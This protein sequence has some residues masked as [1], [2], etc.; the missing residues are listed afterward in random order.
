[1]QK[2][3]DNAIAVG[4]SHLTIPAGHYQFTGRSKQLVIKDASNLVIRGDGPEATSFWF[5]PGYGVQVLSCVDMTLSGVS[6]DTITPSHSQSKFVS[7]THSSTNPRNAKLVVD[8]EDGFPLLDDPYLFNETCADGEPGVCSE[9]KAVF[10]D[11]ATRTIARPQQMS[12]PM[13]LA[14]CS[15]A[16]RRCEV[17]LVGEDPAFVPAA[18]TLVTFSSRLWATN[19]PIPSFYHGTHLVYNCTRAVFESIDTYSCADMAWVEVLGGGANTYRNVNIKRRTNPPYPPRLLAANDDTFHSMSCEV[20]PTIERCEVGFI[21]DDF[22]NVHNR[23]LPLQSFDASSSSAIVMDVGLTPGPGTGDVTHVM[24]FVKAGDELKI[25]QTG[26]HLLLGKLVVS[27]TQWV[28]A[29]GSLIPKLQPPALAAR[30][31]T[32]GIEEWQ[33]TFDGATS[34]VPTGPIANYTAVVQMDRFSSFGAV[35]RNNYFHDTYNNIARFAGSNLVY[36]NNTVFATGDGIHTSYDIVDS[37]LE[38]SV[39]MQNISIID[40]VFGIV[41][42]QGGSS[43]CADR[44][45]C[46]NISCILDHVDPGLRDKVHVSGNVVHR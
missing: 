24:G 35:I 2:L 20:G 3:V 11:A 30:V 18:S 21:A 37:F 7:I 41:Q 44:R 12:N 45:I 39:G 5:F 16:T 31:S 42:G 9:I 4:A 22:V 8:I 15:A 43:N 19:R 17:Q 34:T 29:G 38:G 36:R 40:N 1:V 27:S 25:Y 28:N 10:W 23:L 13:G 6:T 14:S 32:A 33:V 46:T 26:T